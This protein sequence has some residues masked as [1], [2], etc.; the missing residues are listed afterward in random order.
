MWEIDTPAYFPGVNEQEDGKIK[1]F[2]LEMWRKGSLLS[3][4]AIYL[5]LHVDL[6]TIILIYQGVSK[7][8]HGEYHPDT[9]EE[10]TC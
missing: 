8:R 3:S 4:L 9:G 5:P 1:Y 2:R 6:L 7:Y 10:Q